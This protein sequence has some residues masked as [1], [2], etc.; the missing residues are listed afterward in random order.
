[1]ILVTGSTGNIGTQLVK[2]LVTQHTP[3]RSLV[4]TNT[5]AE[6]LGA[7]GIKT[8]VGDFAQTESL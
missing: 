7:Q 6:K 4:R 1:M 2:Q 5:D 8:V 3:F